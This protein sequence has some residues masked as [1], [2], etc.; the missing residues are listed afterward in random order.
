MDVYYGSPYNVIE[1]ICNA[2]EKYNPDIVVRCLLR[3]FYLDTNLVKS[4]INKIN[5]GYDYIELSN[6]VNLDVAADVS[7]FK[8]LQKTSHLLKDLPN[9][10]LSNSYRFNPWVFISGSNK[11]RTFTM[12]YPVLWDKELVKEIK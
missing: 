1:R 5:E 3:R 8:V 11:F 6:D 7:T 4:M 9:N 12:K 2:S 10:Y